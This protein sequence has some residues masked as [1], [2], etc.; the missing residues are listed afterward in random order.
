MLTDH[1]RIHPHSNQKH[2][3]AFLLLILKLKGCCSYCFVNQIKS[4]AMHNLPRG[5]SLWIITS[6]PLHIGIFIYLRWMRWWHIFETPSENTSTII[7]LS[8]SYLFTW[9]AWPDEKYH[10]DLNSEAYRGRLGLCSQSGWSTW[11]KVLTD[12]AKNM[13]LKVNQKPTL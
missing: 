4:T 3:S 1:K 10:W 7:C 5:S 11:Y 2:L 6:N 9:V 8:F 12:T 13:Q